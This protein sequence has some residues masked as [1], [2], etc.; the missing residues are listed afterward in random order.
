[1]VIPPRIYQHH[2]SAVVQLISS[3]G[4]GNLSKRC[5]KTS[6]KTEHLNKV[7]GHTRKRRVKIRDVPRQRT[8]YATTKIA[9][10]LKVRS[11][12]QPAGT[13]TLIT[14]VTATP[15]YQET[16]AF[17]LL[18]MFKMLRTAMTRTSISTRKLRGTQIQTVT[19]T[20]I[21]PAKSKHASPPLDTLRTT[22]I[23][24]TRTPHE[25]QAT[26]KLVMEK[27][28]TATNSSMMQIRP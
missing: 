23:A 13:L 22:Q 21:A 8:T 14:T 2:I 16:N 25:I 17:S 10:M 28:T 4:S 6:R 5:V 3:I 1:M 15:P 24:T 11:I 26:Q 9:M 18:V 12:Q 19:D 27:T 7:S 20:E